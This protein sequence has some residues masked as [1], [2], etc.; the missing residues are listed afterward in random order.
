MINEYGAGAFNADWLVATSEKNLRQY[1]WVDS[2]M[3]PTKFLP[4][5]RN[6]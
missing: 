2:F 3:G 4:F 1:H 5:S 6:S